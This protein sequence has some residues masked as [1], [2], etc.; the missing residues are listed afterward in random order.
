[1]AIFSGGTIHGWRDVED[2]PS[3][4]FGLRA[5][6][7]DNIIYITGGQALGDVSHPTSILSW[8]PVA[9]SWEQAGNL[10]VGRSH[11]AAVAVPS[12]IVASAC[13]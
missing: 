10:V 12:S 1:M 11:H 13:V 7:I 5:T 4:R 3:K 8:D 6:S 9:E 2:L